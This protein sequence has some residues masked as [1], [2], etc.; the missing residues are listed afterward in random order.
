MTSNVRCPRCGM[1][2]D[3]WTGCQHLRWAPQRGG[4][5]EFAKAVLAARPITQGSGLRASTIPQEWWESQYDWLLDRITVRL[6]V[7]DGYCFGDPVELDRLRLDI[8]HQFAPQP[9]LG[10]VT[11][12]P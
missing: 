3:G 9:E 2:A 10:R 8:W 7:V 6:D 1:A 4:P 12:A 5:L 11:S